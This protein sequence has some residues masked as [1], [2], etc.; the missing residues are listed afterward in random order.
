MWAGL[1]F[2][3][4]T[5][6]ELVDHV[7]L[8]QLSASR[9]ELARL[10][11][12]LAISLSATVATAIYLLWRVAPTQ[13]VSPATGAD[14]SSLP[15]QPAQLMMMVRWMAILGVV[16]VVLFATTTG[17][18][19]VAEYA[20][21]P[22]WGGTIAL[23]LVNLVASTGPR[24][25]ATPRGLMGQL[26]FDGVVLGWLL[27]WAGGVTNPF[28]ALFAF[29]AVLAAIVLPAKLARR[30]STALALGVLALTIVEGTGIAPP[31]CVRGSDA[32]C[33][34]PDPLLLGASGLGLAGI[35]AGCATF[36][37]TLVQQL[38]D[39]HDELVEAREEV[40]AERE[41]LGSIVECMADAVIYAEPG[42][43]IRLRNR[44]AS[45]LWPD[46]VPPDEE[47]LRVCHDTATW[48]KLLRQLA[49]PQDRE[50]HPILRVGERS[51]EATMARVCG[52][53]GEIRGVVMVTRDITERLEAQSWR[54]RQERMSVVGKL[55]AQLAHELNNPLGAISTWAQ[56]AQKSMPAGHP[57]EEHIDT[58][59]RNTDLCKRSVRDLMEYARQRPPER[60]HFDALELT[61]GVAR[62][63]LRQAEARGVD[64][65]VDASEAPTLFADA[66]Q[67]SQVLVNLGMNAI[68]SMEGGGRL[69]L[70]A[71]P[72]EAGVLFEV[73]DGGSGIDEKELEN[74][75]RPF[76]STKLEGTG[77]GLAV[78]QDLVMAHGGRVDVRS[79]AGVGSKFSF[80]IPSVTG[81]AE[82]VAE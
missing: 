6:Y 73:E 37:I 51:F 36:V 67:L 31:G 66:R 54:V 63:L 34:P 69:T 64:I 14:V 3:L 19:S 52:P 5:S 75:F 38:R 48:A 50:S 40:Q 41:T 80:F 32:I 17:Q 42:G 44:A 59:V 26:A 72:A 76:H 57:L 77:L 58:I 47:G 15:I 61:E 21:V 49:D 82:E 30:M 46:G 18:P 62:T 56:H 71:L 33:R 22:L 35:I 2:L 43:K 53:D 81:P 60:T 20:V 24:F 7:W 8:G 23:T 29:L 39:R 12:G 27:H 45:A 25:M 4:H 74:I 13:V 10:V 68:D 16:P 1:T 65:E 78:V 9:L 28:A 55:A 79:E 70:R 11:R